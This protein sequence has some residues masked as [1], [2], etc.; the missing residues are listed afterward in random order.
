MSSLVEQKHG[1]SDAEGEQVRLSEVL[2]RSVAF[3]SH[4]LQVEWDPAKD[5]REDEAQLQF[6]QHKVD[7][8]ARRWL[9]DLRV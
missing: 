8:P 6:L 1:G 9:A 5:E 2:R 4:S 7:M 3:S